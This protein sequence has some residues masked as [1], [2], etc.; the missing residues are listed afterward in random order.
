ME[1]PKGVA[2]KKV[3]KK[4]TGLKKKV[5]K[6]KVDQETRFFNNYSENPHL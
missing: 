2:K 1:K 4:G 6:E 3:V 5:T